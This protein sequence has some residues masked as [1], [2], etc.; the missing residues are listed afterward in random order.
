MVLTCGNRLRAVIEA[1]CG[2]LHDIGVPLLGNYV[3]T[4]SD[5]PDRK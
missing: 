1:N 3:S 2:Q 4:W 5:D